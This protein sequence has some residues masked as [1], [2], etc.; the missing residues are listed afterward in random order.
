MGEKILAYVR[1]RSREGWLQLWL[2]SLTDLRIWV[3]EHGERA[4]IYGFLLGVVLMVMFW[5]VLAL[6]II[7]VLAGAVV[8]ILAGPAAA[9]PPAG[10]A[11]APPAG[12][13]SEESADGGAC[14]KK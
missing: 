14:E 7:A 10:S 3:Q 13:S 8:W 1:A 11:E 2:G 6:A 12:K 5:Y 9:V 4:F